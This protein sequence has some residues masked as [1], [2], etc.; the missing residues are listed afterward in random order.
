[1]SAIVPPLDFIPKLPGKAV[2]EIMK[3]LDK[4]TDILTKQVAKTV[5]A[6]VKLPS[7]AQ[8]DDP[9]VKKIKEQH[10]S[11]M[12]MTYELLSE[13]KESIKK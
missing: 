3:Q 13:L 7:S 5:E 12:M 1:M 8:C 2:S 11:A 4:Q 6:S 10:L 9:R